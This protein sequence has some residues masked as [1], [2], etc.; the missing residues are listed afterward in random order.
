MSDDD[1]PVAL[2]LL[3]FINF[4]GGTITVSLSQTLLQSKL[5]NGLGQ[6]IPDLDASTLVNAGAG[7]LR[8]KVSEDKLPLVIQVYNDSMRSIW[9]LILG[10][11]CLSMVGSLLMEWKSVKAK[12]AGAD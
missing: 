5:I 8:G 10:L 9:Y 12:K 2:S 11:A 3:N 4:F 6:V 7:A 1:V